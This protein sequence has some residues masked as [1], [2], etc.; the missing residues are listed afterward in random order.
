MRAMQMMSDKNANPLK[1]VD[2]FCGGG[3]MSLGMRKARV[4]IIAGIDNDPKCRETYEAN[5]P[6]S[7][8]INKD[9]KEFGPRQLGR[10][11]KIARND[12]NMIFIGCSPCQYWSVITGKD[13]SH[14]KQSAHDSRNL[15]QYFLRFVDHYRPGFVLIENVRGIE[16]R[17]EESGLA[18][19]TNFLDKANYRHKSEL[20]LTNDYGVPQS[21]RRFILVASRVLDSVSLPPPQRKHPATV[22]EFIGDGRLPKIKAGECDAKD[23]LHKSSSLSAT[24]IERLELT[25]MGGLRGHW[26]ERNDLQIDAY[27]NKTAEFFRENYGRMAWDEP[28]PTITTKFFALGCGRFG[29]PDQNRAISLREGAMLQTFPKSYKF[30]T[31]GFGNTARIIGNAVPPEFAKAIGKSIVKQWR[32]SSTGKRARA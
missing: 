4:E 8:F 10:E 27:R 20:L 13:G 31:S 29:H 7:K 26:H 14:R 2:F 30:K 12:D 25:P 15:L 9:I 6:A 23:K 21:R 11:I 22:R 24:N 19:L 5:H 17:P 18:E 1:A 32:M 16:R 28:A 3:G